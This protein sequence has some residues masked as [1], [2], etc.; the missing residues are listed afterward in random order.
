MNTSIA[1]PHLILPYRYALPIEPKTNELP[2]P[3]RHLRI[4]QVKARRTTHWLMSLIPIRE[5][6][7]HL[8]RPRTERWDDDVLLGI[9]IPPRR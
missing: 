6:D 1:Q 2:W 7:G 8:D 3:Q 4:R 9:I 5:E